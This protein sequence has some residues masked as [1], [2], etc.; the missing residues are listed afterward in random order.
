VQQE[1]ESE[2]DVSKAQ[3][4]HAH[5]ERKRG[6]IRPNNRKHTCGLTIGVR[7]IF[8][9]SDTSEPMVLCWGLLMLLIRPV[10]PALMYA[11]SLSPSLSLFLQLTEYRHVVKKKNL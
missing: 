10:L 5:K 9:V 4:V 3:S 7:G 8:P 2:P 6:I 1:E 11:L